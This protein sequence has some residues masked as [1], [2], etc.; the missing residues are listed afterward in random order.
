[1]GREQKKIPFGFVAGLCVAFFV[2]TLFVI[3]VLQS[4]R[5]FG[6]RIQE[7]LRIIRL[8]MHHHA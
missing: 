8:I 1:M 7:F 5:L 6:D 3:Y 2:N 4:N